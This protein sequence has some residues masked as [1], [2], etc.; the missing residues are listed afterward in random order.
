MAGGA[1]LVG[2]PAGEVEVR[3][4]WPAAFV[5][6]ASILTAAAANVAGCLSGHD[7]VRGGVFAAAKV[8]LHI[9]EAGMPVLFAPITVTDAGELAKLAAF[10]P[11]VGRSGKDLKNERYGGAEIDFVLCR[12]RG[13]PC[14]GDDGSGPDHLERWT[15]RPADQGR[16]EDLPD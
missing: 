12:R 5:L 15:D 1:G 2:L 6:T 14:H 9:D 8:T 10:F 16:P 4:A 3:T 13:R 7:A 11:D